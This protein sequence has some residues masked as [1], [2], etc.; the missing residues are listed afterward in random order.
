MT[1]QTTSR[2]LFLGLFDAAMIYSIADLNKNKNSVDV[3]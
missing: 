3:R 1:E 2:K